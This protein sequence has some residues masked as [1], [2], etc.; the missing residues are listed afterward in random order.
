MVGVG[1]FTVLLGGVAAEDCPQFRGLNRDGVSPETGLLKTWPEGGPKKLWENSELGHGWSSLAVVGGKVYTSGVIG[2]QLAVTA[3]DPEGRRIWQRV[4]DGASGGSEQGSR[5]T[6]TV[7]GDRLY[8]I[9]DLGKV[10]CLRTS[11]GTEMWSENILKKYGGSNITWKL[12][13]SLLI[14]GDRVICTPGGRACLT[15]LDKRTGQEIWAADPIEAKPNYASARV[16]EW[17]G[18]R[19]IVNFSCKHVFG[20]EAETG[21]LLWK[22]RH[23][24]RHDVNATT[25]LYKDDVLYITSGYGSGSEGLKMSIT[26]G[27]VSVTRIWANKALD[28]HFGGVVLIGNTVYGTGQNRR[29]LTALE[30]DTGREVYNNRSVRKSSNIYADGRLYC[31][32]HD[33]TVQLVDPAE[34]RVVSSFRIQVKQKGRM[35]AHPAISDRKLYIRHDDTV[36]VFDIKAQ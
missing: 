26:N 17:A 36:S 21:K 2:D 23:E 33:G 5:S 35:W 28:D 9:S 22:H 20:V 6:P 25:V 11:D 29:G 32:G 13:E 16:V 24:T 27:G 8:V 3:L 12:A 30:I 34:G 1:M 10:V 4:I 31:Q 15:A 18:V 14:D 19:Q 7:D